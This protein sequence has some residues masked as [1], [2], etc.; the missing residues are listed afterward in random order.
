MLWA[1]KRNTDSPY[2]WLLGRVHLGIV[3]PDY[4]D[5]HRQS[6]H[7]LVRYAAKPGTGEQTAAMRGHDNDAHARF[8]HALF[9]RL[10]DRPFQQGSLHRPLRHTL[11]DAIE[12]G[13]L[14]LP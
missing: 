12:I 11:H 14:T 6:P 4:Q 5:G 2:A 1:V 8:H 3:G 10:P 13:L 7:Q 9:Q